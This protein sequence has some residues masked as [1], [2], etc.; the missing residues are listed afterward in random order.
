MLKFRDQL[1]ILR[2]DTDEMFL[3]IARFTKGLFKKMF[4]ANV[5]GGIADNIFALN[6]SEYSFL[7]AV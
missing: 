6:I 5:V 4:I 2:Q 1:M 3:G 7:P